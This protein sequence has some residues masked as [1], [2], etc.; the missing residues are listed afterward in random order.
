ILKL[1]LWGAVSIVEPGDETVVVV[2]PLGV[3][4]QDGKLRL[5]LNA[6]YVNLFLKELPFKY[7]RLR[8]V[9]AFTLENYFMSTWDLKSGYYHVMLH[10]SFRKFMGFR[11]GRL[12]FHYNVPAFGLSQACFLFT[13]LMNE[14]AKTLRSHGVPISDYIDD[15]FTAAATFLRCL[16]QSLAAVAKL[17]GAL[18]ALFR[19]SQMPFPSGANPAVARLPG[20]LRNQTIQWPHPV[21]LRADV[22]AS[23]I[24]FGGEIQAGGHAPVPFTGSFDLDVAGSAS[25]VRELT[26]YIAAL[27]VAAQIR[28]EDLNGG[29]LLITGDSQPAINTINNFRSNNP[30]LNRLLRRLFDLCTTLGCDVQARWVPRRNLTRAN[31]LSREPDSSDWGLAL[32]VVGDVIRH[33][34]VT[35]SLD[36]FASARHHVCPRFIS[37]FYEPGCTAVQAMRTDWR[38]HLQNQEVAWVFPPAHLA[39]AA[40]GIIREY[41]I[42]A[43]L[44]TRFQKQSNEWLGLRVAARQHASEPF[45]IPKSESSCIPSLR[46][47]SRTI[48]PAFLGLAAIHIYWPLST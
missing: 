15:G 28:P 14:P 8:D 3:A 32:A 27:E 21:T 29:T 13:K 2:N 16:L 25:A 1:L 22:D 19:P 35:P 5:F 38:A 41:K 9:L 12:L 31:A 34:G 42:N 11:V 46:V 10:P 24:G 40:I 30:P 37:R 44:I 20:G 33:F 23:G 4:D 26:G 18:G 17:L 7:Q 36:V 6:R 47:P 39:H 43:I 48:N 45:F